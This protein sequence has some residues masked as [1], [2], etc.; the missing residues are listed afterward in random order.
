M[1][2][3][4]TKSPHL[5]KL[6]S[7]WRCWYIL[8]PFEIFCSQLIYYM[9]ICY[10]FPR[11]SQF[12]SETFVENIFKIITSAPAPTY[13]YNIYMHMDICVQA[14]KIRTKL[15]T[16]QWIH[17]YAYT[18]FVILLLKPVQYWPVPTCR[19]VSVDRSSNVLKGIL[20]LKTF[21]IV[22]RLMKIVIL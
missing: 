7:S 13:R 12:F 15:N 4:H 1:A 18:R 21:A 14:H 19:Y 2:Y 22:S 11:F 20:L 5:G 3:F 10:I 8:R 9:V 16:S 17:T 6:C